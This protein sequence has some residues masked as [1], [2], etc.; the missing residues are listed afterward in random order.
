[1]LLT[2]T[3]SIRKIGD[4]IGASKSAVHRYIKA[5]APAI[6]APRVKVSTPVLKTN[7]HDIGIKKLMDHCRG[8]SFEDFW[9]I[10][11][12]ISN[13]SHTPSEL[14]NYQSEVISCIQQYRRC[15][16]LKCRSAGLSTLAIYYALWKV[17][18]QQQQGTYLFITGIGYLL[19]SAMCRAAKT[20][21]QQY[22]DK[23]GID[24]RDNDNSTTITFP[25]ARFQFFGSDSKSYRGQGVGT[26]Q[27][28]VY[29]CADEI[30]WFDD[31]DNWLAAIDAFAIKS[32]GMTDMLLITTPSNKLH[33]LAHQLFSTQYDGLY[34]RIEISFQKIE[35]K[36]VSSEQLNIL[37]INSKS[38]KAEFC[39]IWGAYYESGGVYN[40][41]AVDRVVE[42]GTYDITED[43]IPSA[44][45]SMA[46][47]A[48]FGSSA[49]GISILQLHPSGIVQVLYCDELKGNSYE[50]LIHLAFI[51]I[52]QYNPSVIFVD[53]NNPEVIN[54]LKRYCHDEMPWKQHIARL[55]NMKPQPP[56]HQHMKVV[57]VV[58]KQESR[59]MLEFSKFCVERGEVAVIHNLQNSSVL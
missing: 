16:V 32:G 41:D 37:R 5:N 44:T 17:L 11:P 50:D 2:G 31:S 22:C 28:V 54:S 53:G 3:S 24:Y 19:S 9:R 42:L 38:W 40:S 48:G 36:M 23:L 10:A 46:V 39:L 33:G 47:D 29:V 21:I 7:L 8:L 6:P 57:P 43:F 4:I 14:H 12:P 51:L 25:H 49:S 15:A 56:L 58:F 20:V 13:I 34:H 1:L 52:D 45:I 30:A 35:D 27:Q 55:Q 59:S 18:A 26:N